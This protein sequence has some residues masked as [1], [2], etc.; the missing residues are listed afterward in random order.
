MRSAPRRTDNLQINGSIAPPLTFT[1]GGG[2][3]SVHVLSG[4]CTLAGDLSPAL[5]NV[6][7]TIDAGAA[8]TF[9]SAQHL[10][11]LVVNGAASL[12]AG[13]GNVLFTSALAV[14]GK[15]DL[16]DNALFLDY[17]GAD[18][19]APPAAASTTASPA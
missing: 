5:H 15:L 10:A 16:H 11:N 1:A 3:D 8:V 14:T 6:A 18:S 19:S 17:S 9:A 7:V 13:G 12:A 2:N 4:G